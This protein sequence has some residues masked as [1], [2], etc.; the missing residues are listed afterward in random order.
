MLSAGRR[1][2]LALLGG[3]LF[4]LLDDV[5]VRFFADRLHQVILGVLVGRGIERDFLSSGGVSSSDDDVGDSFQFA[6]R[7]TDVLFTAVSR[8]A[9]HGD[10]VHGLRCGFSSADPC[11]QG[12]RREGHSNCFHGL[13]FVDCGFWVTAGFS[14]KTI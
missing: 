11:E 1:I 13:V 4:N 2:G 6:E 5:F 9:R 7:L 3:R 12:Q 14:I 8:D 10:R